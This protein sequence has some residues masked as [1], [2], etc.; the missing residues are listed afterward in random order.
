MR[1]SNITLLD[2]SKNFYAAFSSYVV[3]LK[4]MNRVLS[5]YDEELSRG[6][7]IPIDIFIQQQVQAGKL[8]A[9]CTFPFLTSTRLQHMLQSTRGGSRQSNEL[10]SVISMAVLQSLFFL[11]CDFDQAKE[12]LVS[13]FAG[14][15][16]HPRD[17]IMGQILSFVLSD[18]FVGK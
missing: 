7:L 4:S 17:A 10:P 12:A 11:D 16:P 1:F 3:G 6:P 8:K 14:H 2:L 5:L 18:R 9:A 15:E 13:A